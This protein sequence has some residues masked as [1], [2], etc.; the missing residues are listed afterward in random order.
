[1]MDFCDLAEFFIQV[2][3]KTNSVITASGTMAAEE[4]EEDNL[5]KKIV[6]CFINIGNEILNEDP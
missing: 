3:K 4:D 1:M 2:L 5:F 6:E